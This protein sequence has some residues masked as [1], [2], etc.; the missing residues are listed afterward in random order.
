MPRP[1]VTVSESMARCAICLEPLRLDD[2]VERTPGSPVH[3]GCLEHVRKPGAK[4]ARQAPSALK[5]ARTE[6]GEPICPVCEK[7]IGLGQGATQA[8]EYL[9]HVTCWDRGDRAG[10]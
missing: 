9:L 10:I 4:V 7:P 3:P 6:G 5:N 2:A 1:E 8:R